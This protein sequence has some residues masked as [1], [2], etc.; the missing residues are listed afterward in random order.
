MFYRIEKD[1]IP[2]ISAKWIAEVCGIFELVRKF[3]KTGST[4]I[5][6]GR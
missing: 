6:N 5:V 1:R 2:Q 4:V 3:T